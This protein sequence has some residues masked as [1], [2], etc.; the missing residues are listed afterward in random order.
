MTERI[1][2]LLLTRTEMAQLFGVSVRTITDW[3]NDGILIKV[4]DQ[5]TVKYNACESVQRYMKHLRD[6][7]NGK[8]FKENEAE[9]KAQKLKAEVA[10]KESQG[11]LHKLRTEIARGNYIPIEEVK[12]DYSRF[13]IIFKNFANGLPGKLAGKLTGFITPVEVREVEK[14]IQDEVSEALE[15]FVSRAT[16]AKKVDDGVTPKKKGRP[17]KNAEKV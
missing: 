12:A 6:K 2:D 3:G 5:S 10:L 9:L 11:E 16:V 14:E 1:E 4:P 7:A 15:D 17:R 8:E 13:F